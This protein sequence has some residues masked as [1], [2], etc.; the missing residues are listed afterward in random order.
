MAIHLI[1]DFGLTGPYTG[2]V[3]ARLDADSGGVPAFSLFADAPPFDARHS[4]YLVAAYGRQAA[5]GDVLLC[6]VDPGVGTE[7]GGL[8]LAADGRWYVGPDNGLLEIVARHAQ[9]VEWW[10]LE[11]PPATAS[12]SFHG[13][14]WFAPAAAR[15]A[16][17]GQVPGDRQ[18]RA[19]ATGAGWPE[20]LPEIVYVDDFGNAMTGLRADGAQQEEVLFA[21][22]Q[23]V[24]PG[25]VFA[26]MPPGA[27]FWYRNAAALVEIAVNRGRAADVLSLR[28]GSPVAWRG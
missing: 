17:T 9:Q 16:R 19:P 18:D 21:G 11:P 4:A 14:D 1:T 7:R 23:A 15:I 24:P 25:R 8:A 27:A 10:A 3:L 13:R 22:G 28:V 26:E 6:V 5:P 2:Q 20:D 12:V